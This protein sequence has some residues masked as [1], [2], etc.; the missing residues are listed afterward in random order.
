MSE[1]E[2]KCLDKSEELGGEGAGEEEEEAEGGGEKEGGGVRYDGAAVDHQLRWG[3]L[4]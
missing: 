4:L 2:E 3:L 1:E